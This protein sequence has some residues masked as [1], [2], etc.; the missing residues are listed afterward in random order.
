[1]LR[2]GDGAVVPLEVAETRR[3]RRRGLLGRDGLDGALLLPRARQ[4]HTL[5]M[6]FA[7]DAVHCDRDGVVVRVVRLAPGRLGPFVRRARSVIEAE[8]GATDRW[9]IRPGQRLVCGRAHPGRP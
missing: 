4:V 6:R 2:L 9:G 7:I 3:A 1:M 5:G 8:A